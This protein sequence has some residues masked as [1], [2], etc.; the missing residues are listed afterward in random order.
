ML[1]CPNCGSNLIESLTREEK[2]CQV[3]R[4]QFS[5]KHEKKTVTKPGLE[6]IM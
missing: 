3:C 2:M 6:V 5:V 4:T 1:T